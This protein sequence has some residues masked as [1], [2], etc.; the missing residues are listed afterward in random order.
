MSQDGPQSARASYKAGTVPG[1]G[2][3]A[4]CESHGEKSA[5]DAE[6][7]KPFSNFLQSQNRKGAHDIVSERPPESRLVIANEEIVPFKHLY[8]T[9]RRGLLLP[10]AAALYRN[11]PAARSGGLSSRLYGVTITKNGL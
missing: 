7:G 8:L 9:T 6:S 5:A 3:F 4:R 11:I 2:Q 1:A 10:C